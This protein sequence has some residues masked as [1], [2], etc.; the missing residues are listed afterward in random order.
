MSQKVKLS[1]EETYILADKM[2]SI[3]D[4]KLSRRLLAI[5]LRHYGY[6]IKDIS[7]LTGVSKRTVS[8]WIS[9]FLK[10]G[11]EALLTLHYPERE[12]SRLSPYKEAIKRYRADHPEATLKEV[13][14]WL[15][16]RHQVSVEYSW[17]SRYIR[18][19]QL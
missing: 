3:E 18:Y 12:L 6:K 17:L 14:E 19:Y 11:F 5:S 7:T 16:S 4:K 15:L 9:M 2:K 8:T 13:Q 1:T 10:G